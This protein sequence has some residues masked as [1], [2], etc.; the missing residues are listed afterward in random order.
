MY[1]VVILGGG[2]G[3]YA[4]AIRAAQL[5]AKVALVEDTG[6]GG[7]CVNRG[8][9][10]SKVWLRAAYLK[11]W[12]ERSEEFGLKTT[13]QGWDLGAIVQRKNG[14]GH[15]IRE[16]MGAL[17]KKNGIDLIKGQGILKNA[18]EVFVDGKSFETKKMIIAT[19]SSPAVPAIPG[20]AG[21]ALTAE[22]V[23]DLE[24]LPASVLILGGGPI[25]LETAAVFAAFGT[26]TTLAVPERRILPKEDNG[27]SQRLTQALK[28]QGIEIIRGVVAD[29]I[30]QSEGEVSARLGEKWVKAA[31][32]RCRWT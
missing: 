13:L 20:I 6:L 24:E 4:A 28:D 14:V 31:Q 2:P 16:G 21:V 23:F 29:E 12:I 10:P 7:T 32:N 26:K 15:D 3:G 1:D 8:C 30:I 11:H 9:I 22:Q 19:G 18:K 17:L 25:E 5:K 27:T